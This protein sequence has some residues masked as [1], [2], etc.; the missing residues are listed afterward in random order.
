MDDDYDA[1]Y[2]LRM[3][4]FQK[5]I[6]LGISNFVYDK[7]GMT[8]MRWAEEDLVPVTRG[9]GGPTWNEDMADEK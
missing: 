2:L 9:G 4:A 5:E 7:H 6:I 8:A 1:R 3:C